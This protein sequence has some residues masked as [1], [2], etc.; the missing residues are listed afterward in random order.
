MFKYII[1]IIIYFS[2]FSVSNLFSQSTLQ[3]C[4]QFLPNI[5]W[6]LESIQMNS[7]MVNILSFDDTNYFTINFLSN[8]NCIIKGNSP[9]TFNGTFNF[10]IKE[11]K[12]TIHLSDKINLKLKIKKIDRE[13]LIII[14]KLFPND[15]KRKIYI[16]TPLL[17]D[18]TIF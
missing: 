15:K 7:K 12:I 16:F 11:N 14:G 9:Q 13:E 17:V 3:N 6:E 10:N 4:P 18:G 2:F 1:N 8:G 5:I